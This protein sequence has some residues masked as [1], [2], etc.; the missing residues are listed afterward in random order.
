M[1]NGTGGGTLLIFYVSEALGSRRWDM[2]YWVAL[3]VD[4]GITVVVL[5]CKA[6]TSGVNILVAPEKESTED[7]LGQEIEDT[8]EDSLRVGRDEVGTLAYTPGNGV[9]DPWWV[10]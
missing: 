8:V 6:K 1:G 2:T 7:G 3:L 10:Y 5:N 4:N 9:D